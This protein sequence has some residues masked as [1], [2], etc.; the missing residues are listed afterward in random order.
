[1]AVRCASC[2]TVV[3]NRYSVE[4]YNR[5]NDWYKLGDNGYCPNCGKDLKQWAEDC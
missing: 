5:C 2:W 3:D 4:D 1:M